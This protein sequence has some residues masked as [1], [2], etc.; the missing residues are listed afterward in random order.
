M[1]SRKSLK[2]VQPELPKNDLSWNVE[3]FSNQFEATAQWQNHST[4]NSRGICSRDATGNKQLF[5]NINITCSNSFY[6]LATT[7]SVEYKNDTIAMQANCNYCYQRLDISASRTFSLALSDAICRRS[8]AVMV[9]F[10]TSLAT[11]MNMTWRR[12]SR[13]DVKRMKPFPIGCWARIKAVK[14]R[15]SDGPE[16]EELRYLPSMATWHVNDKTGK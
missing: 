11:T 1:T 2:K 15:N 8:F 6:N 13:R 4:V 9:W 5:F 14:R 7:W 12:G 3:S 10:R 16:H